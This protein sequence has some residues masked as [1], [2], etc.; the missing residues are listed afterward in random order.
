V[1]DTEKEMTYKQDLNASL[2]RWR[3]FWRGEVTDRPPMVVHFREGAVKGASEDRQNP[4]IEDFEAQ[5]DPDWVIEHTRAAEARFAR[6][7]DFPD[8]TLPQVSAPS[9]LAVTGWLFGAQVQV[10]A[11]IP[12]VYP[13]LEWIEDWPGL[14][15]DLVRRRFDQILDIDRLLVDQSRGRYAVSAAVLDGPADMVVRLLSEQKLALALYEQPGEVDALFSA[16]AGLWRELVQKKL[17]TLPLY[18]GGT[19]TGWEYWVPGKGIALQEDFGQMVSPVQF[20]E[21]I[22]AHDRLLAGGMDCLWFHVHSGA[23]HMAREIAGDL[24]GAA[25]S[26]AFGAVQIT[27]DYPAGPSMD[28]MLPTLQ[29]IQE[30]GC[31]ILRKFTLDQL[32]RIVGHLSP[33]GLAIDIQCYDS[34][35]T[36]DIQT[37][38][39]SREEATEV[40]R[41]A[42]ER[43]AR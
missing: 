31:L 16:L 40:L 22:L 9:G 8:D 32:D 21:R 3:A 15:F 42:E 29:Y 39:M 10:L 33:K 4:T 14:D 23:M 26:Q 35:A 5:F 18:G 2:R 30:R 6:R 36:D 19:A 41:W 37:T 12:W 7:A 28:E 27:N 24:A 17:R 20:R 34:T 13:I 43:F 11:G 25:K 38:F 1:E